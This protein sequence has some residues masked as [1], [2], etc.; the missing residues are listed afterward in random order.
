MR[1]E[2]AIVEAWAQKLAGTI[3]T[4]TIRRLKQFTDENTLPIGAGSLGN[5]W[6][7]ICV[8]VQGERSLIWEAYLEFAESFLRPEVDALTKHELLAIWLITEA[9]WDWLYDNWE[10]KDGDETA[11]VNDI[12]VV[13]L[14]FSKLLEEAGAFDNKRIRHFLDSFPD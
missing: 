9:G 7:E 14:L 10:E 13:K 4:R 1:V 3:T 12:E 11:P 2:K 6:E 8:Q 5:V